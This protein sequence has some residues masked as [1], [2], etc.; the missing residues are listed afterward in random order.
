MSANVSHADR[1]LCPEERPVDRVALL[2]QAR[3][4]VPK[5][6]LSGGFTDGGDPTATYPA[7]ERPFCASCRPP[8]TT[9][10]AAPGPSAP[11]L[12]ESHCE[13]S[14]VRNCNRSREAMKR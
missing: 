2:I 14:L 7:L 9:V 1:R 12:P 8:R 13:K 3:Q 5:H 11:R 4:Q 6:E 10:H